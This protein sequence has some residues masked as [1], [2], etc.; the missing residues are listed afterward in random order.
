MRTFVAIDLSPEVRR[1]LA[2]LGAGLRERLPGARWVHGE[3][4]HLTLRFLGATRPAE[5]TGLFDGLAGVRAG[6]RPFPLWFRG[7]GFFPKPSRPRVLWVGVHDPSGALHLARERVERL[8]VSLGF[9]P[10]GR[11]FAPHLTLA[12]WKLPPT[13]PEGR[14]LQDGLSESE[15]GSM[16]VDSLVVYESVLHPRGPEY[17]VLERIGL[18]REEGVDDPPGGRAHA[19]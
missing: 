17:R 1:S 10:E 14:A 6:I 12:R 7:I 9:E 3:N 15:W 18:P 19:G 5:L 16:R 8:A 11:D 4:L 2:D 13:L